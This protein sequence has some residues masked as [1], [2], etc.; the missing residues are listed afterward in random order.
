M[1]T[2][3]KLKK[4]HDKKG[5]VAFE[6]EIDPTLLADKQTRLLQ[7]I[8]TDFEKPGFRRGQVPLETVRQHVDAAHLLEDAAQ[9][10][11]RIVV[12]DILTDQKLEP[13]APPHVHITKLAPGNPVTFTVRLAIVPSFSL[14]DYKKI[15]AGVTADEP[16]SDI[17]DQELEAGIQQI[18]RIAGARMG[19][20]ETDDLPELTPEFVK[21]LGPFETVDGFRAEL[22]KQLAD[23]KRIESMKQRRDKMLAEIV[24][25]TKLSV[26]DMAV[27]DELAA[28]K[29]RRNHELEHAGLSFEDYLKQAGKT[30]D[31]LEKEER[32]Q[33]DEQIRSRLVIR[34]IV[35]QEKLE[36]DPH[37]TEHMLQ[38][39]RRR[40]GAQDE[41]ELRRTALALALQE[42]LFRMLEGETA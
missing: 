33:M 31:E 20:K 7:E 35:K 40:Y 32:E 8:Q 42:K 14:P 34:E 6:A 22:R 4:T 15:A 16:S 27:E 10:A 1:P 23:E 38:E 13:L 36:A 37:A 25:K 30:A 39:L 12:R 9:D 21:Q 11:L 18:R 28:F 3:T 41:A 17:S 26:P 5:E 19:K 2:Y 24:K 29:E